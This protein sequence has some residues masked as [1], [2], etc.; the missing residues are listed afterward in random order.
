MSDVNSKGREQPQGTGLGLA[1]F[2]LPFF[3][4]ICIFSVIAWVTARCGATY[5]TTWVM[6]CPAWL[7]LSNVIGVLVFLPLGFMFALFTNNR[8]MATYVF[9]ALGD[10]TL[11]PF[12]APIAACFWNVPL[13]PIY[14][15]IPIWQPLIFQVLI[16]LLFGLRIARA[17]TTAIM[18]SA[19]CFIARA[20][21]IAPALLRGAYL[22]D[23]T[24]YAESMRLYAKSGK[25]PL[26]GVIAVAISGVHPED[27]YGI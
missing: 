8:D 23:D 25:L 13:K 27:Y 21:A 3:V 18:D 1:M 16:F 12:W 19:I 6:C 10:L 22:Q 24:G 20:R 17:W 26:M 9:A 14:F 5:R 11:M 4:L 15:E 7:I 2:M